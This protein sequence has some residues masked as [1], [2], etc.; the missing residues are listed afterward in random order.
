MNIPSGYEEI[1]KTY[2]N[3]EGKNG[4]VNPVW[5]EE[6]I[7]D[8][9]PPYP[10]KYQND[11]GSLTQINR[12]RVHRLMAP[13]LKLVLQDV[14]DTVR[15]LVKANDGLEHTSEYYDARVQQVIA[16]NRCNVYSG[17]YCF[18]N[19]RGQDVPSVHA[20]GAA[21]DFDAE[22]NAFGAQRGTLPAWFIK[23]F[24]DRGWE[25]GGQWTSK[26]KDYMHFELCS[27]Y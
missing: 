18:R 12:F 5:E 16:A 8:F 25:W 19:K 14:L 21:I 24:T 10:F 7:V 11:D 15:Q 20:F 4:N 26:D 13:E 17:A 22:H 3:P 2:G 9:F 1:V 27:H 6:N 23:C